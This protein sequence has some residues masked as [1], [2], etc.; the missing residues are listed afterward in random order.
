[1][2]NKLLRPID[3]SA[4]SAMLRPRDPFFGYLSHSEPVEVVFGTSDARQQ[5]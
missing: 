4:E 2:S 3:L 5:E 1:M